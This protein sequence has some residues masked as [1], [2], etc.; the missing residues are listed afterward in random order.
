MGEK[1]PL[2]LSTPTLLI[3][4]FQGADW[5]FLVDLFANDAH[6]TY[7]DE[8]RLMGEEEVSRW[9][10][11]DRT[12]HLTTSQRPFCLAVESQESKTV[13]GYI[14]LTFTDMTHAQGSLN[15][16]IAGP[17]Q[18]KGCA[19][20]ALT[21]MLEFCLKKIGMHRITV[22]CDSRNIPAWR[23]LESVG[24]RREGE[25][26]KDRLIAGEWTNTICYAMLEE[27]QGKSE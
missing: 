18:R 26:V 2:P 20:E 13:I 6:F 8:H 25:F 4:R 22:A 23:L 24:M 12:A 1:I 27:E 16:I 9:L 14:S 17:H 11:G 5:K 15:I 10:E 3:R 21:A 7:L 19:T